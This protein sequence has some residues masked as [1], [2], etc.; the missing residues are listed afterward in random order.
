MLF[1]AYSIPFYILKSEGVEAFKSPTQGFTAINSSAYTPSVTLKNP[2]S[3]L[4][5]IFLTTLNSS[6]LSSDH[7]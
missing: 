7:F 3:F 2:S 5:T 4:V 6:S 1:G